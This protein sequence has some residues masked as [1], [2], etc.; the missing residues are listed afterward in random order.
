MRNVK[1]P[2]RAF[3][4]LE[5]LLVLMIT[6]FVAIMFSVTIGSTI[7][8]VRGELF[9]A[10]FENSYKHAQFQAAA[11]NQALTFSSA[12]GFL[13]SGNEKVEIPQE[14]EISDFSVKFDSYGNNSS[15]KKI[16]LSLPYEHKNVIY[17]LEM[18]S[19]KY[20]KTIQ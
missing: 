11:T 10:R 17:Q 1:S 5:T 4:L 2:I 3:T 9:I 12:G 7:H 13:T 6:S 15:L 20:K 18:G 8:V 14:A 19:G 16:T